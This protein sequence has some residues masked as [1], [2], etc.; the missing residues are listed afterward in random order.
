MVGADGGGQ[1]GLAQRPVQ[2]AAAPGGQDAGGQVER[3]GPR[4]ERR[5]A[6]PAERHLGL[7]HVPA[8]RPRAHLATVRLGGGRIHGAGRRRP[9]AVRRAALREHLLLVHVAHQGD[10]GPLRHVARG[11]VAVHVGTGEAG[12]VLLVPD[13]PAA[14][15]VVV[16]HHLVQRLRG[17]RAGVVQLAPGLLDDHLQLAAELVGVDGRVHQRVALDGDRLAQVVGREHHV[18]GGV[19]VAGAGVEVAAGGLGVPGDLPRPAAR[20][21]LEEH[22]LQHVRD[23]GP[24]VRFVEEPGLHVGHHGGHGGGAV[25]LD[26]EREAVG[27]HL[28]AHAGGPGGRGGGHAGKGKGSAGK[29]K[30]ETGR[31]ERAT[32]SG[33]AP[34]PVALALPLTAGATG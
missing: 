32:G 24:A 9:P 5:D 2:P 26:Q 3:D 30:R 10:D 25:A 14:D 4:I 33:V 31:G 8:E 7:A 27:Q 23:P 18:V 21:A 22:V 34:L 20:R 12:E 15:A 11:V 29:W 13:A 6:A 28:A 1:A 19:I 16:V 17:D